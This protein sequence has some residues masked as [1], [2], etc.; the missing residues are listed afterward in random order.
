VQ[1]GQGPGLEALIESSDGRILAGYMADDGAN[2]ALGRW[3]GQDTGSDSDAAQG[4]AHPF[5][6]VL[7]FEPD[8]LD[9]WGLANRDTGLI[10]RDLVLAAAGGHGESVTFDLTLNGLGATRNLLTLAF[11]PPFLAATLCLAMALF[12]A[13]W[14]SFNRFGPPRQPARDIPLG[15]TV[16]VRNTAGLIRRA[17]RVRLIGGPYVD[18]VRGRLVLA[19]GLPRGRTAGETDAAIDQLQTRLE[20]ADPKFSDIAAQLRAA[21]RAA[22]VVR[23]AAALQRLEKDLTP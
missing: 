9:N 1:A 8:L 18:A 14:R 3:I 2:A 21:H 19:L 5:P 4:A 7:V 15:K 22:D 17:G 23:H 16:L 13:G 10:A 20:S 6:V 12:A 11:E